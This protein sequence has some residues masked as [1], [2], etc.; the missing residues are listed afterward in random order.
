MSSHWQV[1]HRAWSQLTPP[2]RPHAEVVAGYRDQLKGRVGRTLLLGVTPEL[3]DIAGNV[4][5][6]DRN[7][8]MIEHIWPGNTDARHAVAADWRHPSFAPDSFSLCVGDGSLAML[9]FPDDLLTVVRALDRIIE[10]GG[11]IVTRLYLSPETAETASSLKDAALSGAVRNFHAFKIRLAMAIIAQRTSPIV[12][13]QEI[14]D[15]F[16]ALFPDRDVLPGPAGWSREQI[17][18]IDL[19]RN[20]AVAFSFP[21]RNQLL[22][23]IRS[24]W[25]SA[26]LVACGTYDMSERC[27]LMVADVP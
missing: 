5:A 8:A 24:V 22:P 7:V 17:D 15:A 4:V 25:P 3:A 11:R 1:Y 26:R 2:L 10:S 12:G 18:T 27:P 20:S 23:I 6:V 21:R 14:L 13:V 19:Y 16:N 9:A